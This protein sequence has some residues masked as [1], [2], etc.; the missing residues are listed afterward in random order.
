MNSNSTGIRR[1]AYLAGSILLLALLLVLLIAIL[2]PRYDAFLQP[3]D[4]G[5]E[6]T[7]VARVTH[8]LEESAASSGGSD[9][10]PFQRLLL[11]AETGTLTGQELSVEAGSL[12]LITDRRLYRPG[13]RVYVQRNVGPRGERFHVT[14]F[15]RTTPLAWF[16]A[17]FVAVVLLVG[18]GKGLRALGG[19]AFSIFI[20]FLLII[21]QILDG[22]DPIAASI[23]GSILILAV[24]NYLIHGWSPKAHAAMAGMIISLILT[25]ILAW[26][27][28]EWSHLTGLGADE[29]T[30]LAMELGPG[31]DLSGLLLGGIILGA[32][33][34]LDDLCVS[35]A[36]A[37]FE[38]RQANPKLSGRQL[39]WHSLNIGRDH[40]AA[41]VNTLP[42]AYIGASL[43]LM[44]LFIINAE[45]LWLRINLEPVAEEIV[46]ALVGSIG[47]V[48]AVP[49]TS[50][51]ASMAARRGLHP[52]QPAADAE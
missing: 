41:A 3:T 18:W 36:S 31:I 48:L 2:R 27:F 38:L 45:P 32:L 15:A 4:A 39:F 33:G 24:S 49:I 28:I 10:F 20:I 43:P 19:M 46:R 16:V 35:Q 12:T 9:E 22:R 25:G 21:P 50:L 26:L 17:A 14:D 30:F 5:E 29:S 8:V 40:I 52:V 11:L 51:I 13:D 37:V 7:F 23:V 47:L 34:V 42:L 44:L 1:P 6:E